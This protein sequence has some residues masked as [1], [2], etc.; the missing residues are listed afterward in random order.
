MR[1]ALWI[2]V[3]IGSSSSALAQNVVRTSFEFLQVPAAAR[4][5]ALGNINVSLADRDVGFFQFNPALNGDT[6]AGTASVNYQFYVAGIGNSSVEYVHDFDKVGT[7]SF[8]VRHLNYGT[9]TSF[10]AAGN[11]IGDYKA[12]ESVVTISKS[13]QIG[14]FRLGG[15]MKLAFSNLAG[16]RASALLADVG[17]LFMHPNGRLTV[18]MSVTNVGAILSDYSM[19]SDTGLPFDVQ[20]G[21]TFKPERLPIRFSVTAWRLSNWRAYY[22]SLSGAEPSTLDQV[23]RHFNF[24]AEVLLHRSVEIMIGYNHGI[25]QELKVDNGGGAA[26]LT[27]GLSVRVRSFEFSFSRSA[28]VTGQAGYAFSLSQDMNKLLRRR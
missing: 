14:H 12:G 27:F 19:T 16:Y 21:T 17:G 28:Y 8:G 18:G 26:G 3:L 1:N 6:L 7:F 15:T 9:L 5:S 2:Y 4:M 20:M 24:A 13:H 11:E 23:A 25:H 22:D 10:D